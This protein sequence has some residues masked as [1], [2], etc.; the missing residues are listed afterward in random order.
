MKHK[1]YFTNMHVAGNDYIYVGTLFYNMEEPEA[2]ALA[3]RGKALCV[4]LP[5]AQKRTQ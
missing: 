4:S 3:T 2:L 5:L 1:I